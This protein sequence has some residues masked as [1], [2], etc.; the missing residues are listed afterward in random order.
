VERIYYRI[1]PN[2]GT[3]KLA[4]TLEL[5]KFCDEA[6][7]LIKGSD[8]VKFMERLRH[9]AT[10]LGMEIGIYFLLRKSEFL[11]HS[12]VRGEQC[13]GLRWKDI[14]FMDTHGRFVLWA[15]VSQFVVETVS[16]SIVMSKTDQHGEGRIRTHKRQ[17]N[18]HCIVSVMV[19]WCMKMKVWQVTKDDFVF[20]GLGEA[21]TN[22]LKVVASMRAIVKF[23]GLRDDMISAHSLRYGGATMLAAAGFPSYIIAYFGGWTEDSKTI[24]TYAQVGSQA[25][26]RVS[27]AMSQSYNNDIS[28]AR[29]R[30]NTLAINRPKKQPSKADVFGGLAGAM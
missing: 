18:G 21:L 19:D 22:D 5:V 1:N 12:G 16:I 11:P 25:V 29:I 7:G 24:R 17:R 3:K 23:I 15:D 6:M 27:W 14:E 9:D 28:E 30:E 13:R 2:S 4:F 26:E 20:E 8:S 10:I